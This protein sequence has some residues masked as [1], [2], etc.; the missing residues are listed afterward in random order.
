MDFFL[1]INLRIHFTNKSIKLYVLSNQQS[2][3]Y[4]LMQQFLSALLTELRV[5]NTGLKFT[6]HTT[7]C[8]HA[9]VTKYMN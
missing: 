4:H 7:E 8:E 5:F 3:D 6:K 1:N 2:I 9:D